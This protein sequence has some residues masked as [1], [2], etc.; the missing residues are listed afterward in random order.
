MI[1]NKQNL[2]QIN[3]SDKLIL[4]EAHTLNLPEKVLQFGTGVLLRGLPDYFIDKA[5][6]EGIF[7]GR[8]AVV[9]ST[10][11]GNSVEFDVQDSLY[12]IC[13]RG[14]EGQNII[15]QNIICSSISRVLTAQTQWQEILRI[16][17]SDDLEIVISN[18]TEVGIQLTQ[19]DVHACPPVSFPGKLLA[20][21]YHRYKEYNGDAAKGLV[22]IPT[23]LISDNGSRLKDIVKELSLQN[24]L[25]DDF[26]A[27]LT[28]NNTFCNSLVDRIVPGK[29]DEDTLKKLYDEL[30][31]HDDLL[32]IAEVYKLWAIEGDEKVRQVLQFYKADTGLIITPDINI[33]KELKL[34]LLNGTHTLTCAVSFLAGFST[35]R[36]AFEDET[37]AG[38]GSDLMLEEIAKAIPYPVACD[39]ALKFSQNVL[40]RFK[41]PQIRHLWLSISTNYTLKLRMRVIPVLRTY[42][43][44]FNAVPEH[45]A[46]GFAAY[47]LF[48][49]SVERDGKYFGNLGGSDYLIDDEHAIYYSE[50]W[51]NNPDE[52]VEMALANED[53]WGQDLT[54]LPGFLTSVKRHLQTI[55]DNGI[56]DV[57][58]QTRT[59]KIF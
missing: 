11:K 42:F 23:E 51:D 16:A 55:A 27:W 5:N 22:I 49:K 7:N 39:E 8:V 12:T 19:D 15:E 47:L 52:V 31:Y 17:A 4:P 10:G 44:R 21:L 13:V 45:I 35:V 41:N 1:L 37:V 29:P 6:R 20:I 54:K 3:A 36:E 40:D 53:L 33:Y 28:E 46:L 25:G 26:I 50:L 34:R 24:A 56:M 14:I 18:T 58:R 9:K 59:N 2:K 57:I 38:F 48:M 30:G 43:E 32:T